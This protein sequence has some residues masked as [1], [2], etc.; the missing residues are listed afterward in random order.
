MIRAMLAWIR[1]TLAWLRANPASLL[2]VLA[3]FL[4]GSVSGKPVADSLYG[5]MW[6]DARF[7]DDCHVH[8]WANE[9]WAASVHGTL[10]TCHD[11]HRVPIRHY[12]MNL[13]VTLVDTPET[14]EDIPKAEVKMVI[15]EQ[16]HSESGAEEAVT[17]PMPD[18][19]RDQ[20]VRIDH[21]P[22]HRIHLD[23]KTRLPTLYGGG[24]PDEEAEPAEALEGEEGKIICL[25]C[26]G[27]E[28]L[29]VHRFVATSDDCQEC[30]HDIMPT[31]EAGA[32]LSCL[33][34]HG[35]GFVGAKQ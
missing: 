12:P 31:D 8:D 1:A 17:G 32:E 15:C 29:H 23:A 5:Y 11:C 24:R 33:D 25:D 13:L 14:P 19:V 10:T 20:V 9:R 26:H 3:G 16:C 7:C 6:S 21:S 22:L 30:H 4:G 34:C 35:R 18:E 27:G 2:V 28:D